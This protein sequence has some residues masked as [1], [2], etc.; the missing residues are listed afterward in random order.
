MKDM[1]VRDCGRV[2]LFLRRT[3]GLHQEYIVRVDDIIK[4]TFCMLS[5]NFA[6]TNASRMFDYYVKALHTTGESH[7]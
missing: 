7:V 4:Q 6:Y 5:D 3:G 2:K 1:I